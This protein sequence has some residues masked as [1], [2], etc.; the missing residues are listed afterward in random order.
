MIAVDTNV[1]LRHIL[2]DDKDQSPRATNLIE[3]HDDILI[4]DVVL[5]ETVWTL[6]GQKYRATKG[7]IIKLIS[8]LLSEPGIMFESSAVIWA[9]LNDYRQVRDKIVSGQK[10]SAGFTDAL[11][12]NK[13]KQIAV[14]R[15]LTLTAVYTFDKAAS[16]LSS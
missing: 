12:V 11:I 15:R 10:K 2:N 7:D 1:L 13:A 6:L 9:A 14:Y 5:C 3:R 16:T 8:D 4:T